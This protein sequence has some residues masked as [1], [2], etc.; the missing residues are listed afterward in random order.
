MPALESMGACVKAHTSIA[1][2]FG[3][4]QSG[5]MPS[6]EQPLV[7]R[8]QTDPALREVVRLVGYRGIPTP[9]SD[10]DYKRLIEKYG[11]ERL[12]RASEE[13][14][15]IDTEKKLATLKAEVRRLCQ[16]ILGPSPEEWDTFYEGIENPPPNPYAAEPAPT[17]R[18][19]KP[20]P[21]KKEIDLVADAVAD[22]IREETGMNVEVRTPDPLET[23]QLEVLEDQLNNAR[24]RCLTS[25]TT[26]A[27]NRAYQEVQRLLAE[28]ERR[29]TVP[30]PERA[31]ERADSAARRTKAADVRRGRLPRFREGDG[32]HGSRNC[33]TCASTN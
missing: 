15:D 16:A 11:R 29:K 5:P 4:W 3:L 19:R 17:K 9:I 6:K 28:Y 22:A 20:R 23:L 27:Q 26:K 10:A 30:P 14:V 7:V 13:L 2:P 12:G 32:R 31:K 33:S 8:L 24:M 1:H 25:K 18:K 21:V